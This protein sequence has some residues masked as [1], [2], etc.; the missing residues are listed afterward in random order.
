MEQIIDPQM[1]SFTASQMADYWARQVMIGRGQWI[2][3]LDP[4]GLDYREAKDTVISLVIPEEDQMYNE[5]EQIIFA[6]AR[7]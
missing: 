2:A 5:K 6:A 4:R 7:F 3:R 1:P